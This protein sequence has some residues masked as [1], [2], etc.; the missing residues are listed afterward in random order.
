MTITKNLN[1]RIP[2]LSFFIDFKKVF[3]T[4]S[5]DLLIKKL[6]TLFFFNNL[7]EWI[8]NYLINRSQST[9][10]N[11]VM[12]SR[13]SL[14]YGVP[15]GTIMGQLLFLIYVNDMPDLALN[16]EFM[17]YADDTVSTIAKHSIDELYGNMQSD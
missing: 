1:K 11:G 9:F 6:H 15:Q 10:A 8:T 17:L 3:D 16:S 4:I 12:S 5:H 14:T 13:A 7:I 2:T